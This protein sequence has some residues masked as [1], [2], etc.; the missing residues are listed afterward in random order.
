MNLDTLWQTHR[1]FLVATAIGLGLFLIGEMIVGSLT[2]SDL[3][4]AERDIRA[5][6][7]A[8]A[9]SSYSSAQVSQL[10]AR[11]E[12]LEQ[13]TVELAGLAL[14]TLRQGFA[15]PAGTSPS[16]HYI[17][18]TGQIRQELIAWA[19]RQDVEVD[20]SLG[21]PPVSPTESQTIFRVLRGLDI[22]ERT[23]RLAVRSGARG[24]EDIEITTRTGRHKRMRGIPESPLDTTPVSLV[25]VF[26]GDEVRP[27]VHALLGSE[28]DG[29]SFGLVACEVLP[30]DPRRGQRR[31]RISLEA[32]SLPQPTDVEAGL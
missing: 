32:G 28:E 11:L 29:G 9:S 4:K 25:V 30:K 12:G 7:R 19:L 18:L 31:V 3:V 2:G 23:V 16:R 5:A 24:V 8:L 13:R 15:A 27:F 21:L 14:P 1:Q 6:K 26:D 22:V 10:R 20:E 17:E